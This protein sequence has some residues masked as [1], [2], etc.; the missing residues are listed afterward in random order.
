MK[1]RRPVFCF[2]LERRR[3]RPAALAGG[4]HAAGFNSIQRLGGKP[5]HLL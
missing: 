3:H 2:E 4:F 5:L 1:A